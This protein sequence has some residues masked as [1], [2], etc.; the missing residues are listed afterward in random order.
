MIKQDLENLEA[1]KTSKMQ[2]NASNKVDF[3][4]VES[5]VPGIIAWIKGLIY[6][7]I[8]LLAQYGNDSIDSGGALISRRIPIILLYYDH[9]IQKHIMKSFRIECFEV[10]KGLGIDS[11]ALAADIVATS[12]G[13]QLANIDNECAASYYCLSIPVLWAICGII[14]VCWIGYNQIHSM[15]WMHSIPIAMIFLIFGNSLQYHDMGSLLEIH[16]GN[17]SYVKKKELETNAFDRAAE[18]YIL[19]FLARP[20]LYQTLCIIDSYMLKPAYHKEKD[21][22]FLIRYGAI[23]FTPWN[24]LWLVICMCFTFQLHMVYKDMANATEEEQDNKSKEEENRKEGKSKNIFQ[25]K[26]AFP[27]GISLRHSKIEHSG[28]PMMLQLNPLQH[29]P[30]ALPLHLMAPKV[31]NPCNST[32]LSSGEVSISKDSE[33]TLHQP[34]FE[35]MDVN[36]VFRL[37]ALQYSDTKKI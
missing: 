21:R 12:I 37:A 36:E 5:Y 13:A 31:Q 19:P 28:N 22:I 8:C 17:N 35:G 3:T 6:A 34:N 25:A 29:Q 33:S 27:S 20:I 10:V 32:A 4:L 23:L 9:I 24:L 11:T 16:S 15:L 26:E 2:F 7:C 30:A 14:H 18:V 1:C